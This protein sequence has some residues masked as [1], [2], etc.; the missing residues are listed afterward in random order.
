ME[1]NQKIENYENIGGIF[2][3]MLFPEVSRETPFQGW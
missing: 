3:Q 2:K 1:I